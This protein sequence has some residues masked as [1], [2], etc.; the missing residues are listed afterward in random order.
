MDDLTHK[1]SPLALK[2]IKR[3][4]NMDLTNQN[5]DAWASYQSKAK[6]LRNLGWKETKT[7][8]VLTRKKSPLLNLKDVSKG[9]GFTIACELEDL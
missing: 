2:L 9:I 3:E 5:R 8:W 7:G 4:L 6:A 1:P